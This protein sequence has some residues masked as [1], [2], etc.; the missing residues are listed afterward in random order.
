MAVKAEGYIAKLLSAYEKATG[1]KPIKIA[2]EVDIAVSNY[3]QYRNGAEN[4]TA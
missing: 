1:E 3:Y 2:G 4:P